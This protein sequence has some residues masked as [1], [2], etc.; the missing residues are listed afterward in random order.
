MQLQ[1]TTDAR[2]SI[3]D[4][5]SPE[6]R[7]KS[8]LYKLPSLKYFVLIYKTKII[9]DLL[10]NLLSCHFF[11]I[12]FSLS[13][14]IVQIWTDFST[15]YWPSATLGYG[16]NFVENL[17]DCLRLSLRYHEA[18][19]DC[20]KLTVSFLSSHYLFCSFHILLVCCAFT[21]LWTLDYDFTRLWNVFV[22]VSFTLKACSLHD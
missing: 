3:L 7:N 4:F 21:R 11:Y 9:L 22:F 2:T 18:S 19:H 16:S 13:L 10:S 1:Q 5:R 6:L 8:V 20:L 17:Q 14:G 15:K 12:C